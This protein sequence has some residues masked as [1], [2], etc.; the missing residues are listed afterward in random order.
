[1][2]SGYWVAADLLPKGLSH[3][4][5]LVHANQQA[6]KQG[7]N[8]QLLLALH[9]LAQLRDSNS[10]WKQ[11]VHQLPVSTSQT[12]LMLPNPSGPVNPFLL[13][14]RY[15]FWL[16]LVHWFQRECLHAGMASQFLA[17]SGQMLHAHHAARQTDLKT[18]L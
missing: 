14:F 9:L 18:E 1:M 12:D 17:L 4:L 13:F 8:W 7:H 6:I 3:L 16:F 10:I 2:L 5:E 11:Y 15:I